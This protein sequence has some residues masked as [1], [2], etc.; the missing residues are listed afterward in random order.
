VEKYGTAGQPT[1]GSTIRRM[2]FGCRINKATDTH[3]E[4]V[5]LITL[6]PQTRLGERA[7]I[8]RY[9]YIVCIV[10]F[11]RTVWLLKF[12]INIFIWLYFYLYII[13]CFIC[14]LFNL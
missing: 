10:L 6:P 14:Y 3:S 12:I 8:L 7:S 5:I 2:R 4:Y 13:I 9:T 11:V 1:D